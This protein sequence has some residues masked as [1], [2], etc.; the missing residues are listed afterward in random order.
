MDSMM[1]DAMAAEM[2]SSGMEMMDM[3][4]L[5]ACMDA[6]AACE[7]RDGQHVDGRVGAAC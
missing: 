1:M 3:S 7:Q 6:C 4:V 5:Q 2:K